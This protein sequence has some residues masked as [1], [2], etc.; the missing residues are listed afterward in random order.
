[1]NTLYVVSI[2]VAVTDFPCHVNPGAQ[3]PDGGRS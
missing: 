3:L 1:M 2:Y